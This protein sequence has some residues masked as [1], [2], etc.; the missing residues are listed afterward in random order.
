MKTAKRHSGWELDRMMAED[1]ASHPH[2]REDI[3][4]FE[5]RL[6]KL[7]PTGRYAGAWQTPFSVLSRERAAE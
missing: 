7:A 1:L 4:L 5:R 3:A 2:T 6:T